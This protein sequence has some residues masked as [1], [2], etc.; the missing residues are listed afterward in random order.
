VKLHGQR[1]RRLQVGIHDLLILRIG[2]LDSTLADVGANVVHQAVDGST[3]TIR[4]SVDQALAT[5]I[6]AHI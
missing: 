2:V 3:K 6:G 5:F 1:E 4:D